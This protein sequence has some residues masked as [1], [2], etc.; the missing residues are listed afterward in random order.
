MFGYPLQAI[1]TH[2]CNHKFR[3]IALALAKHEREKDYE[4][5][6]KSVKHAVQE[7]ENY[8]WDNNMIMAD[9]SLGIYGATRSVFGSDYTHNVFSSCMEEHGKEN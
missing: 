4:F 3:L 8:K 6:L 5:M 1:G 7:F 2:D 9:G